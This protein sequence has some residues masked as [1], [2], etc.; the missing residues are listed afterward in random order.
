[1]NKRFPDIAKQA[2]SFLENVGYVL[3]ER[4]ANCL[5][6]EAERTLITVNRD[7]RSGEI[8]VMF[9]LKAGKSQETD[10]FSLTD[11]LRMED[12]DVPERKMPFQVYEE[13]E[14]PLFLNQ[15]A[16]DIQLYAKHALAGDRMYFRRLQ[17]F[18]SGQS[19]IDAK[20]MQ[21]RRI[22]AQADE[23]WQKREFDKVITLYTTIE[24]ELTAAEKMKLMSARDKSGK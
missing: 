1:M 20:D 12:V 18:R 10:A 14:L 8:N 7:P 24:A 21:I 9:G 13:S 15:L 11:L 3:T 6:C 4:D 17:I 16:K 23:A 5:Q 22:R 2:F 19:L